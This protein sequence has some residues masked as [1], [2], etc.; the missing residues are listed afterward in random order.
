MTDAS[1]L[2]ILDAHHHF[3]NL[4][5]DGYYPWLQGEYNE[6]FFLGD[7][8]GM[9]Q[10][11][12]PDQY[13][14]ATAGYSVI[15]TV[16]VEAE[17]ARDQEV[18]ETQFLETLHTADSRF[19]SAIVA[20]A[21]LAREDTPE[22][23]AQQAASPLVRGI[24]SKPVTAPSG[25]HSVFGETG[26]LQ[27]PR[28]IEG[29]ALLESHDLSWDLRVPY[30]HLSEAAEVIEQLPGIPVIINHC[31]LPLDRSVDGIAAWRVG[32]E[33]LAALPNTA[34]KVSELG[35]PRNRWDRSSNEAVVADTVAIFGYER[36]MFASNLPVATLTAPSFGEV[37]DTVLA[38]LPHA[39]REQLDQLFSGTA[40]EYYRVDL[41]TR[42]TPHNTT[43]H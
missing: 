16:H 29:L 1:T 38:G 8:T 41:P 9:L 27:D 32:M 20:H 34:V 28:F 23:L 17:R 30:W 31:G 4:E 3:W 14:T 21:S 24:R 6:N 13:R 18:A 22:V 42:T 25:D 39:S 33:A 7:Y 5:G 12:L 40:A 26:T 15:G 10:T 43:H 36:S 35:L 11:F 37:V 19:P 2:R